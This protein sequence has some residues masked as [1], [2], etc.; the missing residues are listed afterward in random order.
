MTRAIGLPRRGISGATCHKESQS[1]KSR[2]V[3]STHFLESFWTGMHF[4]QKI[5]TR[6]DSQ[7]GE[8]YMYWYLNAYCFGTFGSDHGSDHQV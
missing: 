4:F 8:R 1:F 5:H 3:S 6:Q 7:S 2:Q